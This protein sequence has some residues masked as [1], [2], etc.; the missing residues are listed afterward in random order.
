MG[1]SSWIVYCVVLWATALPCWVGSTCRLTSTFQYPSPWWRIKSLH[2]ILTWILFNLNHLCF[3]RSICDLDCLPL[4]SQ[5]KPFDWEDC[6]GVEAFLR[7]NAR[8]LNSMKLWLSRTSVRMDSSYE[9]TDLREQALP[10]WQILHL[11]LLLKSL[12]ANREKWD[13][14]FRCFQSWYESTGHG[15]QY[16]FWQSRSGACAFGLMIL[17]VYLKT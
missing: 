7:S 6:C 17:E 9:V 14:S 12:F 11:R 2:S 16:Y 1:G 5:L 4:L 10:L 3:R 8:W 13:L 15:N